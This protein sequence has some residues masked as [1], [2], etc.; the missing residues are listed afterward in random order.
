MALSTYF[1]FAF[2]FIAV[3]VAG[4]SLGYVYTREFNTYQIEKFCREFLGATY[5]KVD[6]E[7]EEV[8]LAYPV[9]SSVI[10]STLRKY[11]CSRNIKLLDKVRAEQDARP[12]DK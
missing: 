2:G 6:K 10:H 7:R 8:I 3:L 11:E 4:L 1:F 12:P 9:R 5:T